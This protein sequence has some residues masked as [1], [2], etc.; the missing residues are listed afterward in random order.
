MLTHTTTER[1]PLYVIPL[2]PQVVLSDRGRG[3]LVNTLIEINPQYPTIGEDERVALL[4]ARGGL[5]A[6]APKGGSP[7]RTRPTP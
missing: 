1:G 7:A 6:E 4:E 2:G 3:G 5:E